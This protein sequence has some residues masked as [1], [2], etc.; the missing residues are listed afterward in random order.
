[1]ENNVGLNAPYPYMMILSDELGAKNEKENPQSVISRSAVRSAP[2]WLPSEVVRGTA[3]GCQEAALLVMRGSGG[4]SLPV[5]LFGYQMASCLAQ[6]FAM[7][8]VGLISSLEEGAL[9]PI[10]RSWRQVRQSRGRPLL[11]RPCR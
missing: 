10:L 6:L 2:P 3:L 7:M 1:M 4:F 11:R 9:G 5:T 8:A